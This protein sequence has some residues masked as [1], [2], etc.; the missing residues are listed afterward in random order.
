MVFFMDVVSFFQYA[1][2]KKDLPSR[3]GKPQAYQ[4]KATANKR[5][6][7]PDRPLSAEEPYP[8]H[9]QQVSWLAHP[10]LLRLLAFAM[11]FAADSSLTV[12][13]SLRNCT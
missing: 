5:D 3:E 9:I 6:R 1:A 8:R 10:C 13:G 2:T 11:A 7:T 12:T 4:N